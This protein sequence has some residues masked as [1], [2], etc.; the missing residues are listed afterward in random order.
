M[1]TSIDI[2]RD[3]SGLGGHPRGLTTLFFTEMWER[4]SYYGMRALLV[5]YMTTAAASG[6]LGFDDKMAASI[7][8]AYTGSVYLMSIPGGWIADNVLGTRRS[9]LLGGIVIAL[10]HFAMVFPAVE[11]F[12]LGL[13]LIVLGTGLLK[14]NVS[15]LVGSLYAPEDERRDAG[16]SVFYMG[17]NLGAFIA[18]LIC[19]YLGEKIDWHLGFGMAGIGMTLG[20]IQYVAGGARLAHVGNPPELS[21]ATRRRNALLGTFLMLACSGAVAFLWFGPESVRVMKMQILI[22]GVVGFLIWLFTKYLRPEE[23]KPVGVIVILFFF[24]I[25]FWASFEQAGSSFNLFAD[26]YTDRSVSGWVLGILPGFIRDQ[27]VDGFPAGWYQSVNSIFLIALAPVF[28]LL[29]LRLRHRQPSSPAKFAIGLF[30]T[31]LGA[32]VLVLASSGLGESGNRVGPSWLIWVYLMQTIGELCLSPVGLS[33]TTKLA[34]ARLTGL[35]MGVWFLSISFGNFLAGEIAGEFGS[36][37]A[38]ISLFTKVAIIPMAAALILVL[39]IPQI[40]RMMGRVN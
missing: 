28:S 39:L 1:A 21:A 13:I 11:T 18:P 36:G 12:Y 16:F 9:V 35:M 4:F 20:L 30:F 24:S 19:S 29:W 25:L 23:K 6:G 22:A 7:Y 3:S 14:P 34:P 40:K 8:G 27:V 31:G 33:T 17:I 37:A 10:G 38:L 5:L 26:R 15:A 32:I 2:A